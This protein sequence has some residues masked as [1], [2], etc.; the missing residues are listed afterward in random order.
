M[1]H[2][3]TP[4]NVFLLAA[5]IALVYKVTRILHARARTTQ[6]RGPAAS[7]WLFGVSKDTRLGDSGELYEAWANEYGSVYHVPAVAGSKKVVVTDPKAVAHVFAH[8]TFTY[9]QTPVTKRA[10][11]SFVSGISLFHRLSH[12]CSLL[13]RK[14]CALGRWGKSQEV[15]ELDLVPLFLF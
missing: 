7:S 14:R 5:S 13:D 12:I 3:F 9:V 1:D 8:D 4:A 15:N 2:S 6:L 10:L 11:E